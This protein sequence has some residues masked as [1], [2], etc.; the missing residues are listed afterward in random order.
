M[1]DIPAG[2]WFG[3]LD[4]SNFYDLEVMAPELAAEKMTDDE[5]KLYAQHMACE[6]L[7]NFLCD[8]TELEEGQEIEIHLITP[9]NHRTKVTMSVTMPILLTP[10]DIH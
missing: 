6:A 5:M 10:A 3:S 7:V 8:A 9:D 1:S 4:G 2:K